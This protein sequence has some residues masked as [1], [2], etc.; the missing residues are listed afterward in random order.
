MPIVV[1]CVGKLLN[2]ATATDAA[3]STDIDDLSVLRIAGVAVIPG[4][5]SPPINPDESAWA[6]SAPINLPVDSNDLLFLLSSALTL[7]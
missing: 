7:L 2:G 3:L 4:S 6:L 5:I 1:T